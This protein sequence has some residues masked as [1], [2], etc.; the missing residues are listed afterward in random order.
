MSAATLATQRLRFGQ[1]S[2]IDVQDMKLTSAL[3]EAFRNDPAET[4][5]R[6]G[7]DDD[8]FVEDYFHVAAAGAF[9][10][11]DV[12][13][14]RFASASGRVPSSISWI[15]A[16]VRAVSGVATPSF[17]PI[18]TIGR[19]CASTSVLRFRMARSRQIPECDLVERRLC[20]VMSSKDR[21]V[22]LAGDP[23]ANALGSN[24][25]NASAFTPFA[26]A[27]APTSRPSA[28][29]TGR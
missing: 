3:R 13:S 27:T 29:S 2:R 25:S 12:N 10:I 19:I 6:S 8:A 15:I 26:L 23:G 5:S 1:P 21:S 18:S 16:T 24:P 22:A 4:M 7:D 20:A 28:D 11:A 9:G 14:S 17:R